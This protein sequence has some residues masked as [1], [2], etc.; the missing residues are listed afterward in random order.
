MAP[1]FFGLILAVFLFTH[2]GFTL[3]GPQENVPKKNV[4]IQTN[5]LSSLDVQWYSDSTKLCDIY[6]DKIDFLETLLDNNLEKGKTSLKNKADYGDSLMLYYDLAL[7]QCNDSI[8]WLNRKLFDAF[9]YLHDDRS[10]LPWLYKLS[11]QTMNALATQLA[12][13]NFLVVFDL[14]RRYQMEYDRILDDDVL[15]LYQSLNN[16]LDQKEQIEDDH[17]QLDD[18]RNKLDTRFPPGDPVSCEFIRDVLYPKLQ[19]NPKDTVLAL[20]VLRLGFLINDAD[21]LQD[22]KERLSQYL[23]VESDIP[24]IL[25]LANTLKKSGRVDAAAALYK[26]IIRDEALKE[27]RFQS[28]N[29]LIDIYERSGDEE[30]ADYFRGV[31]EKLSGSD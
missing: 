3:N 14:A 29:A 15:D 13:R 7:E 27:Y 21:C 18:I 23:P 17:D 31:K 24:V 4:S 10:K 5:T 16:L 26:R 19:K 9:K 28:L 1:D 2:E 6:K 25:N 11:K 30:E 22:L 20:N 8:Q 12:P